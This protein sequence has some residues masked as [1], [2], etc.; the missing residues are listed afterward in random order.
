MGS[1]AFLLIVLAIFLVINSEVAAR[2]L[3]QSSITSLEKE[4]TNEE[5]NNA[6]FLGVALPPIG[7]VLSE[8]GAPIGIEGHIDTRGMFDNKGLSEIGAPIGFESEL[9]EP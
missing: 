8:I 9:V 7:G 5:N 3:A 6:K 1:K 4:Q 2:K